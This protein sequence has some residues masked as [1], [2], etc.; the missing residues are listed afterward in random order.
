MHQNIVKNLL[1]WVCIILFPCE[2]V[3]ARLVLYC[4]FDSVEDNNNKV[5]NIASGAF[6]ELKGPN[7]NDGIL[8]FDGVRDYVEIPNFSLTS[9]YITIVA[10]I[11]IRPNPSFSPI[12]FSCE[13]NGRQGCGI[14]VGY[15]KQLSYAYNNDNSNTREWKSGLEIP[16][17]CWVLVVIA[18]CPTEA[19][20]YVYTKTKGLR[21][22][23]NKIHHM[24]Q[25]MNNFK[26]GCDGVSFFKGLIDEVAI[27]DY[28]LNEDEIKR[29]CEA[30]VSVIIPDCSN[31]Q[32]LVLDVSK[33]EEMIKEQNKE[34]IA[35]LANLIGRF[36]DFKKRNPNQLCDLLEQS[37]IHSYTLLAKAKAQAGF[38]SNEVADT[39]EGI[40]LSRRCPQLEN[41]FLLFL[42]GNLPNQS[43]T[44]F[45]RKIIFENDMNT[46]NIGS[47]A[48]DFEKGENWPVFKNCLDVIYEEKIDPVEHSKSIEQNL[49]KADWIKKYTDYCLN[50]PSLTKFYLESCNNLAQ[51][52]FTQGEYKKANEL[53]ESIIKRYKLSPAQK[54][55]IELKSREIELKIC[56][57]LFNDGEYKET[58]SELDQ[59][60]VKNKSTNRRLTKEALLMKGKCY[61][62]LGE[63]NKASDQF[64]ALMI[65]YPETKQAP[66]ANFF[67]GYCHMLQGNFDQAKE[68]LNL[69]VKDY[70]QSSY[71]SKA[72]LCLA[73][74]EAMAK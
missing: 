22:S 54:R 56:E 47:L 5:L 2:M 38:S 53:Y 51:N 64:L 12:V 23:T 36:E 41:E 66:E 72:K 62:Q 17:D 40:V 9:N 70:P 55:E 35:F 57:S 58:L 27:F 21:S 20:A 50:L 25:S 61:V 26:I 4:P 69:V 42:F 44:K 71:V 30:G 31:V 60:I 52:C 73:R 65:E 37:Y 68:A 33:A 63:V 32:E 11:K 14:G 3:F 74:I 19:K 48:S 24:V 16:T 59:V 15:N 43:Y 49:T 10:R 18:I 28:C 13:S 1:I 39:Y 6:C 34:A 67:I 46:L 45:V 8:D 29:L 7:W